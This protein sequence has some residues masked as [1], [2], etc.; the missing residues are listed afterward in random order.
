[1][2]QAEKIELVKNEYHNH[3]LYFEE[4]YSLVIN[5]EYINSSIFSPQDKF[6]S[7]FQDSICFECGVEGCNRGGM[8]MVRKYGETILFL[9]AFDDMDE[10]AECNGANCDG[11]SEC[12]PHKWF[13][14]GILVVEGEPLKKLLELVPAIANE[15][16]REIDKEEIVQIERWEALVKEQPIG[17]MNSYY[18]ENNETE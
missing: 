6:P 1:M 2:W 9:P 3:R 8:L 13:A 16:I 12:P 14:D 4:W 11:D 18:L 15:N 5:D 10:W 7:H 17:F